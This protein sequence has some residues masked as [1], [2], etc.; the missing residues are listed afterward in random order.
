MILPTTDPPIHQT[1]LPAT[2]FNSS[3]ITFPYLPSFLSSILAPRHPSTHPPNSYSSIQIFTQ[4]SIHPFI[5]PTILL[6]IYPPSRFLS[7]YLLIHTSICP[8]I[9]HVIYHPFTH[10]NTYPPILPVIN[11]PIF[12]SLHASTHPPVQTIQPPPSKHALSILSRP[13]P[14]FLR[15]DPGAL[16]GGLSPPGLAHLLSSRS[17]MGCSTLSASWA[18]L[19]QALAGTLPVPFTWLRMSPICL[20]QSSMCGWKLGTQRGGAQI[21]LSWPLEER[22]DEAD[23]WISY[24]QHRGAMAYN[25][26]GGI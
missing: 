18:T 25:S 6:P 15:P 20:T 12:P 23:L 5:Y 8:P 4:L 16:P 10:T 22:Q 13:A 3:S 14:R 24:H 17:M 1:I 2:F 21:R 26:Q 19:L 7:I 9:P 11:P